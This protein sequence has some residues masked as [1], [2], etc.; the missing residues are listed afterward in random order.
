MVLSVVV[1]PPPEADRSDSQA[2]FKLMTLIKALHSIMVEMNPEEEEEGRRMLWKH[3]L[4]SRWLWCILRKG[5]K[6]QS[7]IMIA[8]RNLS[9]WDF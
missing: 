9:N 3:L 1:A 7:R 8:N 6:N 2:I 4:A 5:F